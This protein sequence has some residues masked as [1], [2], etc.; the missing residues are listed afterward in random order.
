MSD[1]EELRALCALYALGVLGEDESRRLEEH[2]EGGCAEC[3]R[4]LELCRQGAMALASSAPPVEPDRALRARILKAVEAEPVPISAAQAAARPSRGR[5]AVTRREAD[6]ERKIVRFPVFAALGWAAAVALAFVGLNDQRELR[7]MRGQLAAL[8]GQVAQLEGRLGDESSWLASMAS[9]MARVAYF[10][11]TSAGSPK[12]SGWALFDPANKRAI[13][14]I[15]NL[16]LEPGHD[17]EL[18]AIGAQGPRS[19]GVISVEPGGR[20]LVKL[21]QMPDPTDLAAFAV[22]YEAAGGSP[23]PR[24]PAGPVVMV[25]AL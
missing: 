8:R 12:Q 16:E 9:P 20:A 4:E 1:H 24:A 5:E 19:L 22:S 3:E 11:P 7:G 21:Q 23:N 6:R 18:W 10:K 17:F 14:V 2:L 25:G 13:F 15:E